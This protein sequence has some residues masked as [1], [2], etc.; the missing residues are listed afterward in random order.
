MI[1]DLGNEFNTIWD[2]LPIDALKAVYLDPRMKKI[3]MVP[4]HEM[5]EAT[6][7]LK[8]ELLALQKE[9]MFT[10]EIIL[11]TFFFLGTYTTTNKR[12]RSYI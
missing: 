12:K 3:P 11:F 9:V 7:Q 4:Q 1:E 10:L 6:D 2:N 8:L 5:Q